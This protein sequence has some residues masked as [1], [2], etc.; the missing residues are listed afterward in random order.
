M[1]LRPSREAASRSL[2]LECPRT[3]TK[4][5]PRSLFP[6]GFPTNGPCA[7]RM[8]CTFLSSLL[9]GLMK[10]AVNRALHYEIFTSL[11]L[12]HPS[13]VDMSENPETYWVSGR[14]PSFEILNKKQRF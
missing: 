2:T 6:S 7:Q 4:D 9:D 13:A 5:L 10:N 8:P 1:Q 14:C 12:R 3:V 11:L